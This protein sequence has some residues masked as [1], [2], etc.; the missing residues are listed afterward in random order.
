[1]NVGEASTLA[2]ELYWSGT[3][4][5]EEAGRLVRLVADAFG[6]PTPAARLADPLLL[7]KIIRGWREEGLAGSTIN[8]RLSVL[9]KILGVLLDAGEIPRKPRLPSQR[10][11]R[12]AWPT[13]ER[14]AFEKIVERIKPEP[15]RALLV[16]FETGARVSELLRA[17]APDVDLDRARWLIPRAKGRQ[18]REVPLT[19]RAHRAF[20]VQSW[21]RRSDPRSK[22]LWTASRRVLWG[23]W[24]QGCRSAGAGAVRLHDLR[25]SFATRL[26][27]K[28]ADLYRVS[29]LLGHA[30]VKT[31]ERYLHLATEDLEAAIALLE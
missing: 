3:K 31:T 2:F 16:L 23:H 4:N 19:S 22:R 8:R 28:G 13:L 25:H 12:R 5:E 1:M 15:A 24:T 9:S 14:A 21:C 7:S 11:E 26:I 30:S 6:E 17:V 20:Q 29:R 18:P 27:R 10:E